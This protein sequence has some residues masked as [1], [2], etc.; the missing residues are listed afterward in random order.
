MVS[1]MTDR[2]RLEKIY[3]F[4]RQQEDFFYKPIEEGKYEIGS[5]ANMQCMF[6]AGSF[7]K[8]RYFIEGLMDW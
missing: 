4:V 7:Q 5:M 3:D 1:N 6:Q 8:V 2:E